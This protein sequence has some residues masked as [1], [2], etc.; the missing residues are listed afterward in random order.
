MYDESGRSIEDTSKFFFVSEDTGEMSQQ[1]FD[2][3]IR[4][5]VFKLLKFKGSFSSMIMTDYF[6]NQDE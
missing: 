5:Q 2:M 1:S 6:L 3:V 4:E